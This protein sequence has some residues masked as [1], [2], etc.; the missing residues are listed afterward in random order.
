MIG[1]VHR[2]T[3]F[4]QRVDFSDS[5]NVC[6]HITEPLR[7]NKV[8]VA[9]QGVLVVKHR[10]VVVKESNSLLQFPVEGVATDERPRISKHSLPACSDKV[11]EYYDVYTIDI[12][13]IDESVYVNAFLNL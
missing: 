4:D 1:K 12:I 3:I 2:L 11:S 7:V 6:Q 10:A 8:K 5:H 13:K 9:Q